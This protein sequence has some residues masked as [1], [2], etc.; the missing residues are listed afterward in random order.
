KGAMITHES[1]AVQAELLRAA[2]GWREDDTL[3]H[4]LPLHHLHGLGIS[5]PTS[6]PAGGT[7]RMLPR[8]DARRVWDELGRGVTAWM[9][10]PT[11][12]Q[13][14]F[15]AFDSADASTRER[16]SAGAARLRVATSGSAALPVTLAER[17]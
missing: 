5:L 17:W 10:V 16:W 14:L 2:W 9:G 6:L 11:M 7:T 1:L 12:Y 4:A 3:L 15:E 8:F 13:K